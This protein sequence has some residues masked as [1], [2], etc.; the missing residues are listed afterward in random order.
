MLILTGKRWARTGNV[1]A[2]ASSSYLML[3]KQT[4]EGPQ[5]IAAGLITPRDATGFKQDMA[6]R[7]DY[8]AVKSHFA[9]RLALPNPQP[10]HRQDYYAVK[11]HLA[12][13]RRIVEGAGTRARRCGSATRLGA[14]RCGVARRRRRNA[15]PLRTSRAGPVRTPCAEFPPPLCLRFQRVI[16]HLCCL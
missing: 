2:S 3:P 10:R 13:A 16:N 6:F 14:G 1:F 4:R 11:S 8:Y 9:S 5:F 15:P 7:R 12:A